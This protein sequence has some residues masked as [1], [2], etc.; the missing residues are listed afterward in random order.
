LVDFLRPRE[1]VAGVAV[2]GNRGRGHSD[3]SIGGGQATL[4]AVLGQKDRYAP[5]LIQPAEK[6]D[7]LV[8]SYRV[9][10]GGGLI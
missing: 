4:K 2:E 6:P 9:E 5:L 10:L 7:Q 8:T 1:E 3:D